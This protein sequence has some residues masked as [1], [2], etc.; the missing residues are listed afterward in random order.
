MYL[1]FC[2][3]PEISYFVIMLSSFILAPNDEQR[4]S[5]KILQRCLLVKIETQLD[6]DPH[7]V[8]SMA[9]YCN[10]G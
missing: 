5:G 8:L 7:N 9:A 10:T 3:R 1:M 4:V 2:T 6:N